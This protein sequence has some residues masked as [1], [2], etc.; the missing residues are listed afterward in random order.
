MHI[1]YSINSSDFISVEYDRKREKPYADHTHTHTHT[2]MVLE[3]QNEDFKIDLY[4]LS[5]F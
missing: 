5:V 2:H 1:K 4:Y 3:L